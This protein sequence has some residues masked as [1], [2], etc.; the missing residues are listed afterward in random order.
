MRN[1]ERAN[2]AV[3]AVTDSAG[4]TLRVLYILGRPQNVTDIMKGAKKQVM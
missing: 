2:V 4:N 3:A 1:G